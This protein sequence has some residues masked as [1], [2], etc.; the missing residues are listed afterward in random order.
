MKC[1]LISL[2]V[3][4]GLLAL[5]LMTG[6]S[7]PSD[8][9]GKYT[10][11]IQASSAGGPGWQGSAEILLTQA[12][13]SLTGHVTLHHPTAGTVQIPITSGSVQGGQVVFFGHTTLPLGT[14]DLKFAG[15]LKTN[16]I[17][18]GADLELNSLFGEEH[19]NAN[20]Q[21]AKA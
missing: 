12:G 14:V 17:E 9:S 5:S 18:G 1:N 20:W 4:L 3:G 11:P 6:C 2:P 7:S 16:R 13:S 21:L 19:D 10:T 15:L 8:I